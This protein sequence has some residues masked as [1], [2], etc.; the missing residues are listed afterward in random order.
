V[1][2]RLGTASVDRA[3]AGSPALQVA[4]DI[5]DDLFV[6]GLARLLS[7]RGFEVGSESPAHVVVVDAGSVRP[8]AVPGARIVALCESAG[9]EAADALVHGASAVIERD[10][11]PEMIVATIRAAAVG[12][13]A[14]PA[15]TAA[16]LLGQRVRAQATGLGGR[17]LLESLSSRERDVLE[18]IA[19]GMTNDEIAEKLVLAT[20]TVK[21]HVGRVILKLRARNRTHAAVLSAGLAGAYGS[22]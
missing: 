10:S 14:M 12:S 15:G 13:V 18:L 6:V 5:R 1:T 11:P 16:E 2:G 21:H 9:P 20:S 7:E 17:L 4:I 3:Q 19:V 22:A 8:A